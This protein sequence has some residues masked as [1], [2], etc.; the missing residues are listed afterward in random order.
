MVARSI[1]TEIHGIMSGVT[2]FKNEY[3]AC[4]DPILSAGFHFL[5]KTIFTN[6][7]I[8]VA[9]E[10]TDEPNDPET[11]DPKSNILLFTF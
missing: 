10:E 1:A 3:E 7:I 2:M 8:H 6:K 4:A 9:Q 11:G 5:H